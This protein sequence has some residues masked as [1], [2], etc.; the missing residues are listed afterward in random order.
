MA[1][2]V[3]HAISDSQPSVVLKNDFGVAVQRDMGIVQ[4]GSFVLPAYGAV[5]YGA[6]TVQSFSGER[7]GLDKMGECGFRRSHQRNGRAV[8][9]DETGAICPCRNPVVVIIEYPSG[10]SILRKDESAFR[11]DDLAGEHSHRT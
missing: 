7:Y 11:H 10:L 1:V 2:H 5:V 8:R 9:D 4:L 3:N 6:K